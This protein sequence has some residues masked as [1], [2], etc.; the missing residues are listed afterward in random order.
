M[1]LQQCWVDRINDKEWSS[2]SCSDTSLYLSTGDLSMRLYEYRLRPIIEFVKEWQ[3][4]GLNSKREGILNFTCANGKI[5]LVISN[6]HAFQRLIELRLSTTFERLWSAPLDAVAHCCSFNYDEWIV[7]ELLEFYIFLSMEKFGKNTK[8]KHIQ[9][10]LY[11][12]QLNWTGIL[13]PLLS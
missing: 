9:R 11:R 6:I 13:L 5:A 4:F 7:K 2:G 12:V 3:L 10:I 1:P 8:S